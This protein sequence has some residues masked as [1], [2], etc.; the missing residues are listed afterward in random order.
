MKKLLFL[1]VIVLMAN[2]MRANHWVGDYSG[3]AGYTS[4]IAVVEIDGVE[5]TSTQLEVGAFC[6][7]EVRGSKYAQLAPG[8]R[9]IFR[10]SC[11]GEPNDVFTFQL[12]DAE[13]DDELDLTC[14]TTVTYNGD[15]YGGLSSPFVIA[16]TTPAAPT[17][18]I[19]ITGYGT[20]EKGG[21]YLIA[22]PF[23][24]I[25]P[26]DVEGMVGDE[27]DFDLY[28]FDQT[29]TL[30]WINYEAGAFNLESGKGYLYANKVDVLLDFTG[31]GEAYEGEGIFPLVYDEN[32]EW[33]GW[34]LVGNPYTEEAALAPY[35]GH[36]R[37][38]FVLDDN[39]EKVIPY[40]NESES[41]IAKMQAIFVRSE[42]TED[43]EVQFVKSTAVH[44]KI[45]LNLQ[46]E[47]G[48]VIDRALVCF[49]GVPSVDKLLLNPNETQLYIP[50]NGM[51]CSVVNSNR[52]NSL[53][54]NL[55]VQEAGTYT[56]SARLI[57]IDM[58]YLH[59]IDNITGADVDLLAQNYQ[60]TATGSEYESRFVL[61]FKAMTGV[62]E[63][64]Q[65]NFCFVTNNNLYFNEETNGAEFNL[66]DMTGRTVSQQIL[67]GNSVS[68]ANLAEGVY[69]V[70]LNNGGIVKTQKIMVK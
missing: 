1:T 43:R 68:L 65:R 34:N 14:E 9:Y 17:Y 8:G 55:K 70:R 20:Q 22:P 49:D 5:Q 62:E 67:N 32:A 46:K 3:F 38:M 12:Y 28:Y 41:P 58:E 10:L 52:E 61:V 33:A 36:E 15:V 50:E 6:N 45:S 25:D 16:F 56:L 7:G 51:K 42:G 11:Y 48:S 4:V 27:V 19:N 47:R 59:V 39:G 23:N 18:T 29:Q 69:V 24:N 63:Q 44:D 57:A 53:P 60:F 26:A 30:E 40:E 21:Y 13:L 2:V 31:L 64:S 66:V 35:D 37:P 54:V